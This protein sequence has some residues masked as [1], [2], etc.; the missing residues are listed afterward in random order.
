MSVSHSSL[1]FLVL[2]FENRRP[3]KKASTTLRTSCLLL[4]IDPV[5]RSPEISEKN[6]NYNPLNYTVMLSR[7]RSEMLNACGL[8]QGHGTAPNRQHSF[9]LSS[10]DSINW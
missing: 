4:E 9:K 6:M 8:L 5:L 3:I 10:I 7:W 2:Q 1:L